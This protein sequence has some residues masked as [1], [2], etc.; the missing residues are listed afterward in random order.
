MFPSTLLYINLKTQHSP[1]NLDLFVETTVRKIRQHYHGG[2]VPK[3]A[4]PKFFPSTLK[5]RA[6]VFKCI[7]FK[8]AYNPPQPLLESS[9]NASP[10]L[11]REKRCVTT[12][13]TAAEETRRAP[14]SRR[15]SV[16]GKHNGRNR[17]VFNWVSWN[18]N[19]SNHSSQSQRTQII[20]WTNQNTK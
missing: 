10:T 19:Q 13:I 3:D 6:C 15:I 9:R 2:I 1:V 14:F 7:R 5:C 16:N 18:Q 11:T 17:A 4:F 20:K 8:E 12:L